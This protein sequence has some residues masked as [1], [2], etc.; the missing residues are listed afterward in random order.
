MLNGVSSPYNL[1]CSLQCRIQG[2]GPG[3]TVPHPLPHFKTKLRPE[4][5]KKNFSDT[6]A[7]PYL[8][9]QGLDGVKAIFGLKYGKD[10]ENRAVHP[11]QEFPGVPPGSQGAVFSGYF[12][13]C[14]YLT[15]VTTSTLDIQCETFISMLQ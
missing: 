6:E 9:S 10:L 3:D 1:F 15:E 5:P 4:G 11:R 7:P 14:E 2:R 8:R 12:Y 13:C